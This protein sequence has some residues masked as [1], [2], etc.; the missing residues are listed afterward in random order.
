M[1]DRIESFVSLLGD[2]VSVRWLITALY[3]LWQGAVIGGLVVIAERLLRGASARPRYALYSAAMLSLP[4]C[5]AVTFSVVDVPASMQS[6]SPLESP[7]RGKSSALRSQASAKTAAV[8]RGAAE[9]AVARVPGRRVAGRE[10]TMNAV[11]DDRSESAWHALLAMLSRAAPW[12]ATAYVVGVICFLLR[13]LTALWGGR[14]LRTR[15]MRVTDAKL[16]KLIADQADRLRLK[17]VPVVAYCE[18]VAAP[19]VLGVLCPMVLLPASLMTGLTPDDF[20][21]ILRHE[22]AHIRRYDLWMNLLQRVVESLLFFHPVVWFISRRLDA[23]RE[24]CC[25]DLVVSSGYEPMDYAGALL[26]MAELCAISRKPGAVALAVTGDKT[27]LLEQRIERLMNWG[28]APRLQLTRAGMAGL[29]LALVALIVVPGIAHTWAQA[30]AQEGVPK[31]NRLAAKDENDRSDIL[32][33]KAVDGIR[34][35]IRSAPTAKSGKRFRYGERLRY[36]VW[37]R[38]ETDHAIRVPRDPCTSFRPALEN[39]AVNVVGGGSGFIFDVSLEQYEKAVLGI[40]PQQAALLLLEQSSQASVR[41]VEIKPGRFGPE[42]LRI[43]PGTYPCLAELDLYYFKVG[44]RRDGRRV[45]LRS[46]A[47]VIQI[48]PAARL[49]IREVHEVTPKTKREAIEADPD[50][51]IIR[52]SPSPGVHEDLIVNHSSE[53]LLDEDDIIGEFA[54]PVSGDEKRYNLH[55]QLTPAASQR[56]ARKTKH[57]LG[58]RLVLQFEGLVTSVEIPEEI[59]KSQY[60]IAGKQTKQQAEGIVRALEAIRRDRDESKQPNAP[61][62]N[63]KSVVEHSPNAFFTARVVDAETG[64]PVEEFTVLAGT[65]R[66]EDIGWQW[67]PHTIHR[68]TKGQMQWPPGGERGYEEQVLRVEAEGYVPYQT[69]PVKRLDRG[70]LPDVAGLKPAPGGESLAEIIPGRIGEPFELLIRLKRDTK[71]RGRAVLPN[72]QPAV[73]AQVAMAMARRE[74]RIV[75]GK[76]EV[77]PL[78][79]NASLGDRWCRPFTTTTD[80]EGRYTLPTEI[81]PAAIIITHPQG[82]AALKYVDFPSNGATPLVPWGSIDGRVIWGKVPGAKEKFDIGARTHVAK[83]FQ[84]VVGCYQSVVTDDQGRFRAEKLPPGLAQ[85]SHVIKVPGKEGWTYRPVQFVEVISGKP[86]KM[87][88]GGRGRP[89]V[90]KLVGADKYKDVHIRIAPNAPH[91]IL[92]SA[93]NDI[94]WPAYGRFLSSPAGKNYVKDGIRPNIDGTFRIEDVPPERYQLFVTG[95][96]ADGKTDYVG[97]GGFT[98]NPIPGGVS[99]QPHAVGEI[100]LRQ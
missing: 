62:R 69:P 67:Q 51:E 25:D 90:G 2:G 14:R 96:D 85:V 54:I 60:V 63:D 44:G 28:N 48:L 21:A 3:F 31:G 70:K 59:Q 75:D 91:P 45:H 58:K 19:T 30:Q 39:K 71:V 5:V 38:N 7:A 97:Q 35:G 29:L 11:A 92:L 95:T 32:W 9:A 57:L 93:P 20:A 26:R 50:L 24:V 6:S 73:G 34:L 74:V 65:T 10:T 15:T 52:W 84:L 17:C 61:N 56:L 41:P 43:A 1:A 18:R 87:V 47:T 86:T 42:P 64:K 55:L 99:D 82:I 40:G 37:I 33:G 49:Q 100:K 88:F 81:A 80:A 72:G 12:I 53:P 76:I 68:F 46:E 79:K 16:L 78:A 94:T 36:E 4:I 66:M 23:E 13:L 89:V 98:I 27:P 83:Q 77:R 22:L 8:A